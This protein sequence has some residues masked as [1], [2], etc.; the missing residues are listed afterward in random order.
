MRP[1][2]EGA[3]DAFERHLEKGVSKRQFFKTSLYRYKLVDR[4]FR[5]AFAVVDSD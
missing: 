1:T 5:E 2:R 3:L 4:V